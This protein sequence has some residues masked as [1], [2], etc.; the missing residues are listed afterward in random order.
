MYAYGTKYSN[1][2]SMYLIYPKDKEVKT[3]V[4]DY[5]KEGGLPLEVLF[6]DLENVCF[7]VIVSF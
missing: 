2:E 6:F 7:T 1:C 4:Y 5:H 3:K